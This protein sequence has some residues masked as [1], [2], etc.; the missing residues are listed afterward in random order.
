MLNE[1]VV[2]IKGFA[3]EKLHSARFYVSFML[4][5]AYRKYVGMEKREKLNCAIVSGIPVKQLTLENCFF[6]SFDKLI[7]QKLI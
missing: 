5:Y 3:L 7:C 6:F 2:S 1:E 4:T